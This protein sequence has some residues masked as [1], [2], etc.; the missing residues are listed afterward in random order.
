MRSETVERTP[1]A[2]P[3]GAAAD[4]LELSEI[5]SAASS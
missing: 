2:V 4:G 3:V 1:A 5:A